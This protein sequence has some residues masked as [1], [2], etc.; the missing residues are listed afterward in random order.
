MIVFALIAALRLGVVL[1]FLLT[2]TFGIVCSSPF[3][4]DQ[5]IR[6]RLVPSV[7]AFVDW[8][9]LW[10]LAA[11]LAT[12]VTLIPELDWRRPRSGRG[13]A[14]QV[15]A[16][17]YVVLAGAEAVWLLRSPYLPLL[18]DGRRS[19][20]VGLV[21]FVPLIW[22]AVIDHLAAPPAGGLAIDGAQPATGQRRLFLASLLSA[23]YLWT[24]HLAHAMWQQRGN[25]GGGA[26][27]WLLTSL[28]TMG[29]T[30]AIF[31]I[32]FALFA[33]AGA[34][35]ERSSRP[36]LV[37]YAA[38]TVIIAVA[39]AEF[40][41]RV[42]LPT[43]LLDPVASVLASVRRR[44]QHHRGLVRARVAQAGAALSTLRCRRRAVAGA[45]SADRDHRPGD[46]V[47]GRLL[48]ACGRRAGRLE[49]RRPS[50]H[51]RCR[52][53]PGLRSDARRR[54]SRGRSPM[55]SAPAAGGARADHRGVVRDSAGRAGGSGA[56]AQS[57]ARARS[58]AAAP[59]GR[60]NRV[61]PDQPRTDSLVR[62]GCGYY[63][64][65]QLNV[66]AAGTVPTT[67]LSPHLSAPAV[68]P[69]D[70][71]LFV[72][73]SLRR[74]YLS[75]YNDAVTFTPEI[76]RLARE[77]FVFRNAFTRHGGTQ[78]AMP[79]IWAGAFGVRAVGSEF[80]RMN[81]LEKLLNADGYR[82]LINDH[83]VDM[84]LRPA[85]PMTVIDPEV[86]S[87]N[88][89]LCSNLRGLTAQLD[90]PARESRPTFTFLSPMNVHI[91]NTRIDG[92][93]AP[94]DRH[95]SGVL[96]SVRLAAAAHRR[97]PGHVHLG[98][99]GEGALRQLDRHRDQRSW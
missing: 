4:Y 64:Y 37:E 28:W 96:R 22:L 2:A 47:R 92:Q 67:A 57:G 42:V 38:I 27:Q 10:Y 94:V 99:E 16:I 32:V 78:L 75:P 25:A 9:H 33:M 1:F 51:R 60:G 19:L 71:F 35:A 91:M 5:F 62:T 30:G 80:R 3:A 82:V 77:S 73:D 36:R 69:P 20:V 68:T 24:L 21:S 43:I 46:R 76:D 72:I 45:E 79:S 6:A 50:A 58:A 90:A 17:A 8:H 18:T 87:K 93:P 65:L 86:A 7:N 55:G 85:R 11:Y 49:Q 39:I 29:L 53:G 95:L 41:R 84:L 63:R 52:M 48:R 15:L 23:A 14:A 40:F 44:N 88:V 31:L 34:L 66:A 83:T 89:D 59:R 12:V 70:I 97:L 13:R 61:Q 81:A 98:L 74:D 26:A 54:R 56:H